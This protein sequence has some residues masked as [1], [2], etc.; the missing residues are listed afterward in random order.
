M[1][2]MIK[3]F[4]RVLN[5][6]VKGLALLAL[7]PFGSAIAADLDLNSSC[8]V[9]VA[10]F[11]PNNPTAVFHVGDAV[12]KEFDRLDSLYLA[13]GEPRIMPHIS[14]NGVLGLV[15]VVMADCRASPGQRVGNVAVRVYSSMRE[16]QKA[17]G[18]LK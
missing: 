13:R 14:D 8:A 3:R 15:A 10:A 5:W 16:A 17:V 12:I 11:A 18:V 9:A 1:P 4:G 6:T 2:G 7:L